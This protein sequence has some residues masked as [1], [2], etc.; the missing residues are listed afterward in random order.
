MTTLN[1]DERWRHDHRNL[2][3]RVNAI[4]P[5]QGTSQPVNMEQRITDVDLLRPARIA[6]HLA[7]G[8]PFPMLQGRSQSTMRAADATFQW[9]D[10]CSMEGDAGTGA[11]TAWYGDDQRARA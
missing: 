7:A 8:K 3:R 5:G 6:N 1:P 10:G 4:F 9:F 11:V 2:R